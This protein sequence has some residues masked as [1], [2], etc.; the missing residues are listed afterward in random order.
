MHS[1]RKIFYETFY[2]LNGIVIAT[3][4]LCIMQSSTA[5]NL[6]IIR[7]DRITNMTRTIVT[8]L[9]QIE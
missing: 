1:Y 6:G 7:R 4:I 9:K 8:I 2:R 3:E 5:S